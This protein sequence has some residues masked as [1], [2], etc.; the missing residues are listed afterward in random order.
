[1]AK[2][3]VKV[4]GLKDIDQALIDIGKPAT[5]K[6]IARRALVEAATPI[7]R[8]WR[9][10]VRVDTGSLKDSGGIGTRL[11]RRQRAQ[12]KKT[13]PVEIHVGPGPHPQAITEEFGTKDQAPHPSLRPAWDEHSADL[14]K[15][16]GDQLWFEIEH[17]AKRAA[18]KSARLKG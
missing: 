15:V 13:A 9:Q 14:P 5:S 2:T 1:M 12:H 16:I 11:T 6:N 7:D 17:A 8:G 3:V 10:R 18:R 4:E